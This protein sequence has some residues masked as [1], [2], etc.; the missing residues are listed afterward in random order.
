MLLTQQNRQYNDHW[1]PLEGEKKQREYY[2][3][4]KRHHT[5]KGQIV[6]DKN[7]RILSAHTAKDTVHDFKLFK[8][9]KL[10]IK[11]TTCAYVD[12]GYL[13]IKNIRIPHKAS[14]LHPLSA[15]QKSENVKKASAR[16]C[17]EHVNAKL[18]TF[19]ILTQKYRNRRKQFNLRFN[20]ICGLVNFDRGFKVFAK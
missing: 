7:E 20:L 6:I 1:S 12:L 14:K 13:G 19:Q 5:L 17:V 16:I 15:K 2:S 9:S 18:K 10:P 3:G 8:Q 4:K 11:P